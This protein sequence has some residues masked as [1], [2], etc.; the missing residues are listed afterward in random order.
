ML[1][2]VGCHQVLEAEVLGDPM[3]LLEA[4][5]PIGGAWQFSALVRWMWRSFYGRFKFGHHEGE[6]MLLYD[7]KNLSV[8]FEPFD[9]D[10]FVRTDGFRVHASV[11]MRRLERAVLG[12]LEERR[13]GAEA[14]PFAPCRCFL[15]W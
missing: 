9:E 12:C 5:V 15:S 6:T 10:G 1:D 4:M 13:S 8:D 11:M 14:L 3:F 7:D 2:L